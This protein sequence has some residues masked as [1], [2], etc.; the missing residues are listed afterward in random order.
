MQN[1]SG[2]HVYR[3]LPYRK[4]A[5]LNLPSWAIVVGVITFLL[6]ISPVLAAASEEECE[7]VWVQ[8]DVNENGILEGEELTTFKGAEEPVDDDDPP[9]TKPQFMAECFKEPPS[10][11][12]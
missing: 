7:A 9:I 6:P 12:D 1:S 5:T 8:S 11:E 2:C 10:Q 3:F 4:T